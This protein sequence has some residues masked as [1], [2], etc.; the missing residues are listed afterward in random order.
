MMKR[1]SAETEAPRSLPLDGDLRQLTI[2][3]CFRTFAHN[4]GK[5][6]V[7]TSSLVAAG[8]RVTQTGDEPLRLRADEV[9]WIL[10]NANW[11]PVIRRQLAATP[12]AGRPVVVIW[13]TEPLPPP[14]A[15]GLPWPRLHARELAKIF[16]RHANATDVY[17]NYWR[18]R[19]LA[20]KGLPDLLAVSTRG[21][22]QF[23][24]ERGTV[25]HW[26]PF[27]YDPSY[28]HDMNL[29]RDIDVLFLGEHQIP[30]RRRL[31]EDLR[32]QGI[33]LLAVG[34]WS[35][36]AYWGENRTRLLNRAKIVLNL[37]RHPGELSGVRFIL[38]MANNALVISELIYDPAPYIPGKHYVSAAPEDFP[39][40]IR[41][42]LT[43]EDERMAIANEGHRFVTQELTM[44][45]SV[46][47]ILALIRVQTA[48]HLA[49]NL[50]AAGGRE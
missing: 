7:V 38:A 1:D 6:H 50:R 46:A 40:V 47:Q 27:G 24:A 28:G 5:L 32:R 39:R 35:D 48:Q 22:C 44:A 29:P 41:Y 45:R 11:F 12:Q 25:A 31:L 4:Q 21:G 37:Q 13:H 49:H 3:F 17:T 14:T 23:L 42:Y 26:V 16:L 9:V 8:C 2:T 36:P 18:L 43:H 30:R 10:G 15:A 20:R 34:S 19:A 33:N